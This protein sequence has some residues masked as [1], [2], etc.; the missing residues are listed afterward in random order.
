MAFS[1]KYLQF[2][3]FTISKNVRSYYFKKKLIILIAWPF[4]ILSEQCESLFHTSNLSNFIYIYFF[5]QWRFHSKRLVKI[6][7]KVSFRK[8]IKYGG[9]LQLDNLNPRDLISLYFG[10]FDHSLKDRKTLLLKIARSQMG[11]LTSTL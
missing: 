1:S 6:Y 8:T 5:F 9:C 11:L 2:Q 3:K 10:I 7:F 4:S